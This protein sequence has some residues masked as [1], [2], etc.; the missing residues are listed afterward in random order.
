[1]GRK[2]RF[3]TIEFPWDSNQWTTPNG[4]ILDDKYYVLKQYA[5]FI[6]P[7]YTRVD[8]SVNSDDIK[9]SAYISPDNQSIS[10]VLLNTSSSSETVALD[11]NGFTASN[12]EIYRTSDDEKAEFIGSLSGGNTVLLPAK[13]ITTVILK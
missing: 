5:K 2:W 7:G 4:Y 3:V 6:K 13:S 1:M 8:A 10:V 11:V 12:S 9:I